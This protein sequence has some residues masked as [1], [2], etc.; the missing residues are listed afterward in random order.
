MD[1][2]ADTFDGVAEMAAKARVVTGSKRADRMASAFLMGVSMMAVVAR[3]IA[4]GELP[5][6]QNPEDIVAALIFAAA[7]K[8]DGDGRA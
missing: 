1:K 8:G 4:S 6:D 7:E 5:A 3:G 2:L